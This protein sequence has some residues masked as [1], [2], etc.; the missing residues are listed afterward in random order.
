MCCYPFFSNVSAFGS[1]THRGVT[2][3]SLKIIADFAQEEL[4]SGDDANDN[5]KIRFSKFYDKQ[6]WDLLIEYCEMP[7]IDEIQGGFKVHFY[8]P[9]TDKNFMWEDDSALS[10]F[11]NHFEAAVKHYRDGDAELAFQKLGRAVHFLEDLNT[12]VHTVYENPKDAIMK[13]PMHMQFEKKCDQIQ[14]ECTAKIIMKSLAYF[15]VN[16]LESIGK[17]SAVLSSENFYNLS[18]AGESKEFLIARRSVLNAQKKVVG[19]FYRF[20]KKATA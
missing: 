10:R 11:K 17:A 5:E 6:Y 12:P 18:K 20:F 16:R 15:E 7:D 1:I 4:E 19:V 2:E 3:T 14:D 13:L 9:A 8:N